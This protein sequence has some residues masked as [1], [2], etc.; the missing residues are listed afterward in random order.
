MTLV[1]TYKIYRSI[2]GT[3]HGRILDSFASENYM[4]RCARLLGLVRKNTFVIHDQSEVDVLGNFATYE[5]KK[6]GKTCVQKYYD[7][8][9][10]QNEVERVVLDAM[11]ASYTSLFFI[12]G[13]STH[14]NSLLL[15]DILT[16]REDIELIDIS[17]SSSVVAQALL[18]TRIVP[19]D[20]LNMSAGINLPFHP[21]KRDYLLA[22]HEKVRNRSG[23]Q[24]RSMNRFIEFFKLH[25]AMGIETCYENILQ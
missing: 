9:E 16:E 13:K 15:R 23:R 4:M 1:D 22:R 7:T 25:K 19:F 14:R 18:F 5:Y 2:Q 3:L 17:L 10:C 6:G 11:V 12:L 8:Q 24:N 21:S 20:E